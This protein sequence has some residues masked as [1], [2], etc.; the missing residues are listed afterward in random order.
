MKRMTLLILAAALFLSAC[1]PSK[2]KAET[3]TAMAEV[4][5][6]PAIEEPN[7]QAAVEAIYAALP[8]SRTTEL[9][10]SQ[11]TQT[12]HIDM[13]DVSEYY[14]RLSDPVGVL[15]DVVILH[16]QS[17]RRET[18]LEALNDYKVQRMREFENYD[19][20]DAYAIAQNAVIY[21]QGDYLI[22]LMLGDNEAAQN[23]IDQYMPQ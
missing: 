21:D 23:T 7:P 19:I 10:E 6:R 5:I 20:L 3:M 22:L 11:L 18:L 16:A 14:G 8:D 15:S 17:G 2:P 1:T 9:D 4:S 13:N 12:L